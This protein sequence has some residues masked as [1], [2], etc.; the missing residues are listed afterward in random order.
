MR[1]VDC[2]F[3]MAVVA[4][5][6]LDVIF[7]E[8]FEK[9]KSFAEKG[10]VIRRDGKKEIE[11]AGRINFESL[12]RN[13]MPANVILL[14]VKDDDNEKTGRLVY[15]RGSKKKNKFEIT[16]QRW[17]PLYGRKLGKL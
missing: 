8:E 10:S 9:L 4:R 12:S 11:R 14:P 13:R 15:V 7:T 16:E 17:D 1:F 5:D 2:I 3:D 6:Y